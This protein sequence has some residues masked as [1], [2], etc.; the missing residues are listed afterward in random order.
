MNENKTK[1][2]NF[3]INKIKYTIKLIDTELK[4]MIAHGYTDPFENELKILE[5]YPE[6][7]DNYPFLIKKICKRQDIEMVYHMLN[8]LKQVEDGQTTLNH[9]E[10]ELGEQLADKYLKKSI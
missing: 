6:F 3:D 5:L 8:K 7:Y 9:I 4:N 10:K 2:N 1:K